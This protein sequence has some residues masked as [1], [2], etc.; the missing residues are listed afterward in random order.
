MIPSAETLVDVLRWR[1]TRA[2]DRL[3]LAYLEDG[4]SRES[5]LTYAELDRRARALAV[6]LRE[7]VP[8]G[9]RALLL[10]PQ[11]L[12]YVVAFYGCLYA[13]VVAVPLYPPA[14]ARMLPRL[15]A[16]ARDAAPAIALATTAMLDGLRARAEWDPSDLRFLATDALHGESADSWR[17]P[18]ID[19]DSLAFLQYT[20]G[21]TASPKGVMVSHGNLAHN[22][23]AL[24]T[25]WE[26][27]EQ[28]VIASW[29]PLFHDM[30][31]IGNALQAV[32]VGAPC[33]LMSPV[34]FLQR[35]LRWLQAISKYRVTT[36]GG[37]NFAYDLCVSKITPAE[38]AA[39]DLS[40]WAVA[41][42]GAEPVRHATL[43]RFVEA[44]AP[45]GFRRETFFP[46]YGLAEST[47]VVSAG[48]RS[49]PPVTCTV[50]ASA[51]EA[52]H[53]VETTESNGSS[54]TL[55][56]CGRAIL[57]EEIAIVQPD[58][59]TRVAAGEVGEIWVS[60][61]SV[62]RGYWR[63]AEET[64]GTFGAT[65]AGEN[66]R[67]PRRFL[68]TGDLGFL[69]DGELF[70]TGR[71]KDL[72]IVR[73]RNHYPQDI[74]AS[75]ET[76]HPAIRTGGSAAFSISVEGDAEERVVV[77]AEVDRAFDASDV[78]SV[79][80]AMR[81]A[82]ALQHELRL[83]AAVLLKPGA[84]P[85][86]TSGKVQRHACRSAHLAGELDAVASTEFP[87]ERGGSPARTVL[88]RDLAAIWARVLEVDDVSID[89]DFFRLGGDSLRAA[90]VLAQIRS[91]IGLEVPI[92]LIFEN[93]TL[94][95]LAAR[96]D[97][98][99]TK[100]SAATP[101]LVPLAEGR[102]RPLSFAQQ[103]LWFLDHLDPG[104][105]LYA[106]P[107][108]VHLDGPL[109]SARLERSLNAVV[110]RHEALR[111]AFPTVEGRPVARVSP[112]LRVDLP[113][114]EVRDADEVERLAALE[115]RRPFDLASG[116]LVRATLY[117]RGS[118][119]HDLL[120]TMH[121]I[122]SDGWSAGVLLHEIAA[123][124]EAGESAA[125]L[126]PLPLQYADFAAWQREC[127][128]G[129]ALDERLDYWRER[130]DGAPVLALP[131]D[132]PRP[133]AQSHR[134]AREAFGLPAALV[135]RL[136][137]LGR[138]EGATLF[139][140][141]LA[142][143][144]V[145]L[146]RYG[147]QDDVC[148]GT[149]LAARDRREFEGLIGFFANTLVMRVDLSGDP[150]FDELLARVRDV[151][152]GAFAH[153][154]LPFEKLV[155]SLGVERSLSHE[156]L[157]Q[158]M[159][160]LQNAA[161]PPIAF[162]GLRATTTEVD[163]GAALVDL[164]LA[165][166]ERDGGLDGTLEYATDLF[167]RETVRRLIAHFRAI[168][169][170]VVTDPGRRISKIPLLSETERHAV[171]DA[172]R[173]AKVAPAARRVHDFFEV[174]AARS[175]DAVA[176]VDDCEVLTYGALD[177][178]ANRLA[179]R[180]L[181]L[182]VGPGARVALCL[183][184]SVEFAVAMLATMKAG[185]AYV[186]LDPTYPKERLA[187]LVK[188]SKPRVI[189]TRSGLESLL[190]KNGATLLSLDAE[191]GSL[192]RESDTR[193]DVVSTPSDLAYVIYTSGSTGTPKGVMVEHRGVANAIE[194]A[195][196]A[197]DVRPGNRVAQLAS[198]SFDASA[199][200]ILTALA[201][202]AEVRFIDRDAILSPDRFAARLR[203]ERVSHLIAIS[204]TL[205]GSIPWGDFPD[206]ATIV[207]GGEACGADNAA[208]WSRGRRFVNAYGPTEASIFTTVH[209]HPEGLHAPPAIGRPIRNARVV[210]LDAG[211]EVVPVG[212]PGEICIGGV[213]VARGYL[214][215]PDLTAERFVPDPF[216]R[217]PQ[218]RLYR[219]GD[220][221][222]WRSDGALEYCGRVDD[223]MKVRGFRVEPGEIE[224]ALSKHDAV[225]ASAVI[226]RE[227]H[228]GDKRLVAY[229]V[230][231]DGASPST[232]ELRRFLAT[233][234]PEHMLPASFVFLDALPR[235]PNGKLDRRAL[236]APATA[237][238]ALER[239]FEPPRS[240][241][242]NALAA[243]WTKVLRID[244][245][246][247]HDNFFELG[248]DSILAVQIVA[249]ARKA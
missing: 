240:A 22:E 148:V 211:G 158:V 44:F 61:P 236:P 71:L 248:G 241:A 96:L 170:A 39:L 154:D 234:L 213:G 220:L 143:F 219:T 41:F 108:R 233:T 53:V 120:L 5:T 151:S 40:S 117:R 167:D 163:R 202:G 181:A 112:E 225:R 187:F 118:D 84:L 130:L 197:F 15:R 36:S 242:E 155:D 102:E 82:V 4:E 26:H 81:R 214:G 24:Q 136:E 232:G 45:C 235:T 34:H 230:K 195:V 209:E 161:T 52:H 106:I 80:D 94:A 38:R 86:T 205:L 92:G 140:T 14:N 165:F 150:T 19:A 68:R 166:L 55:V 133:A 145:L 206:L 7:C 228:P 223:Q 91:T 35:P 64:A 249:A 227:D 56:G 72:I 12:D 100:P 115:A 65:I 212:V 171:L 156:P 63:R 125:P 175:P 189:V 42:N 89:D 168:L 11:G 194:A 207:V 70:V 16:I 203:D 28:S 98:M 153:P 178:R 57:D 103:R 54:K 239:A 107:V 124:Y 164:S 245:V 60:S 79:F 247:I 27:T 123:L 157:F 192:E 200:E 113:L 217:E 129:A 25:C 31:L 114:I 116:P 210:L 180:L 190:P 160:V 174:Q 3:A 23:R 149:A 162:D 104:S 119:E 215:R 30:G 159:L 9:E 74:E 49:A 83:H 186:P 226:V 21:S 208:R 67:D 51:L 139:M 37:P 29:L 85:K 20:S 146:H 229:L 135:A 172:G 62:S 90:E 246:G 121:H 110:R 237:R 43:D 173:G 152:L 169:D 221:A 18:D 198:T 93:P 199:L 134:G 2:P 218:A 147:G 1:A 109:D 224:S 33:I 88:E 177:R 13:G 122:V 201:A 6:H 48:F 75:I 216:S 58:R 182:G 105:A 231:R 138:N 46:G 132:R 111:T 78:R 244:R 127:L 95:G 222:R 50:H 183:D 144:D 141:F 131:T 32:F 142:A 77:A 99:R 204:P 66:G 8:V 128:R 87:R 176:V 126:P 184:R 185:G 179:N 193:P 191:V 196:S 137:D 69:R 97:A 238:P 10:H 47:L 101:P 188:D 243:I 17:R 73:G 59:A 76:S